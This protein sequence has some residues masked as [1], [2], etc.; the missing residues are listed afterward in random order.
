MAELTFILR[1]GEK[2]INE[3][4]ACAYVGTAIE[5][6]GSVVGLGTSVGGLGSNLGAGLFSNKQIKGKGL[7]EKCHIYITNTRIV[8][9]KAK[10]SIFGD[11]EKSIGIMFSELDYNSIKGIS[12]SEGWSGIPA[13]ELSVI[14]K[15]EIDNVK[16]LFLGKNNRQEERDKFL[17]LIKKQL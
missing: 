8:L 2:I 6:I 15:G 9:C 11:E 12:K 5:N 14:N 17:A 10:L 3:L 1:K 16:I 7:A 13:I 4:K